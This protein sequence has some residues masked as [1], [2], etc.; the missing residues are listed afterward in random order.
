LAAEFPDSDSRQ[1]V[2]TDRQTADRG[3]SENRW[4][5]AGGSLTFS[6]LFRPAAILLPVSRWPLLSLTVGLAVCDP[7]ESLISHLNPR[8]KWPNDIFLFGRK[9]CG[10]LVEAPNG[11]R[12]SLIV[13]VAVKVNNFATQ[14]PHDLRETIVALADMTAGHIRRVHALFDILQ[15]LEARRQ[16]LGSGLGALRDEW[17]RRCL[18]TGRAVELKTH[19]RCFFGVCRDIDHDGALIL[20]HPVRLE[21]CLSGVVIGFD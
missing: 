1:L 6:I 10:L 3:R 20:D 9:V 11:Q 2:L 21:Q 5:S 13:V 12:G 14:A 18:L 15:Q 19:S 17:C 16:W 8:I 7:I 4:W